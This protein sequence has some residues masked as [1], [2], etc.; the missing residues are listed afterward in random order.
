MRCHVLGAVAITLA[1]KQRANEARDTGIDVHHGAAG[2]IEHASAAEE[3]A[4][5]HPM[6]YG[7]I[8][9]KQPEDHEQTRAENF[10]RSAKAP[11]IRAG[12]MMAK[13]I[14]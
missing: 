4:A 8:D 7:R 5:P 14:W 2:E 11:T 9:Q 12:V 1:E 10:M 13:V 6:R 3:P